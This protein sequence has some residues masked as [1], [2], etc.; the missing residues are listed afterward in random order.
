[1]ESLTQ[2]PNVGPVLAAGLKAAG[3]A[4]P[5]ALKSLG[6]VEAIRR[7]RTS[8]AEEAPCRSTLSALEG[9]IRGVR[10]H[11]IPKPQRDALWRRYRDLAGI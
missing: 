3:I 9:A 5:E 8:G 1:M 10:W 4:T 11:D 6:S 2:L 7:I